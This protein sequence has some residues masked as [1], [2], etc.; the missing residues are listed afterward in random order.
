MDLL[1]HAILA[2]AAAFAPQL[3]LVSSGFD[4]HAADPLAACR[5]RTS[6]FPLMASLARG[7]A[8]AVA[9][10]LGVVLEGGYNPAV[11]AECV[12]AMLPALS[13]ELSEPPPRERSPEPHPLLAA[14]LEQVG[15]YW[16]VSPVP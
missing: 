1:E 9:A 5:L 10:P 12:C 2:P 14:A 4:A 6:S 3:V 7:L 15:R 8:L 16:P 13:G 11:L